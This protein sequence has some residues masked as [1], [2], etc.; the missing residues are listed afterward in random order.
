MEY[1][2][3]NF[4]TFLMIFARTLALF[5]VA[6]VFG[7]DA[8]SYPYRIMLSFMLSLILFPVTS[9]FMMEVPPG[10]GE[11]GLIIFS[12]VL[13]GLLIGFIISIIF[14]GFLMAGEYFS[15]QMGFSYTEVLDPVSQISLPVMSQLKNLMGLMLFLVTG[16]YR[17]MIESL[18]LSFQKIQILTFTPDVNRSIMHVFEAS[19]GAMF[20]VAFKISLPVLGI[21]I[22]VS[23]SEALMGKAAPQMNILQLSFPAKIVVGLIVMI[24]VIPFIEQQMVD[25][26]EISF[27]RIQRLMRVWPTK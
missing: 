4:Q 2:V 27:D 5:T 14:A 25:S 17:V 10:M 20:V 16:A 26:F 1:F 11:F 23:I 21:L 13:I 7:S 24:I 9:G 8:V 6:P 22:L 12:E 3:Y 18:A 15:V 19:I